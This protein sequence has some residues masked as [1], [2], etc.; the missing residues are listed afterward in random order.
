MSS[1]EKEKRKSFW[2]TLPGILTAIAS[3]IVAITG[4]ITALADH[5]IIGPTP[6]A[7][8]TTTP[9]HLSVLPSGM[10]SHI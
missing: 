5:G 7:F 4:L 10:D 3:L 6:T 9:V 8:P 2:Q 1:K